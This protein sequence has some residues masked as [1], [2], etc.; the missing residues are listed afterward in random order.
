MN[1]SRKP[2]TSSS[3]AKAAL[4]GKRLGGLRCKPGPRSRAPTTQRVT[5]G[6]CTAGR[7]RMDGA[8]NGS[9]QR[10]RPN[11][12]TST[13]RRR[14]WLRHRSRGLNAGD[15]IEDMADLG[16]RHVRHA[17]GPATATEQAPAVGGTRGPERAGPTYPEGAAPHSCTTPM[18]Q[19]A[20]GSRPSARPRRCVASGGVCLPVNVDYI[21]PG[22]V[23]GADRPLRDG[24]PGYQADRGGMRFVTPPDIGVP[25]LQAIGERRSARRHGIWT[26]ATDAAPA[27]Q[28]KPVWTSGLR[29]GA[30]GLRERDPDARAVR[31]HVWTVRSGA[32][33]RQHREGASPW[34]HARPSS[35]C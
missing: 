12:P 11:R 19:H 22:L 32:G 29:I 20:P 5:A 13:G 34:P 28:T 7:A 30:A 3:D 31:E 6:A 35:N 25:D 16:P 2:K 23:A 21:G 27:G 24:L 15:V 1:D 26:E 17:D 14:W 4:R 18:A 33:G 8:D 10:R 9:A